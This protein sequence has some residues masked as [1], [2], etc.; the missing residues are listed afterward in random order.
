MSF[1]EEAR[2]KSNKIQRGNI[3]FS[4]RVQ[5]KPVPDTVFLWRL[6]YFIGSGLKIGKEL[7]KLP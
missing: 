2:T 4:L 6:F 3:E 1:T 5:R 7:V